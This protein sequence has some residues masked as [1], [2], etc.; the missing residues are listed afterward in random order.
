MTEP[1][2][3]RVKMDE[4]AEAL[5]AAELFQPH[6]YDLSREEDLEH[7][8]VNA[9][10]PSKADAEQHAATITST[11]LRRAEDLE[12]EKQPDLKDEFSDEMIALKEKAVAK[13]LAQKQEADAVAAAV[14]VLDRFVESRRAKALIEEAKR[15]LQAAAAAAR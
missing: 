14:A 11:Y 8:T 12:K 10:L 6:G 1:P 9:N 13:L 4:F 2:P 15:T 3:K 7:W 5:K